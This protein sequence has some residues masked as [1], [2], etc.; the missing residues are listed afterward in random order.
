MMQDRYSSLPLITPQTV[1]DTILCDD[2][3]RLWFRALCYNPRVMQK[4]QQ[5]PTTATHYRMDRLFSLTAALLLSGSLTL[6]LI[7]LRLP[8]TQA[9]PWIAGGSVAA[10]GAWICFL[11]RRPHLA[12]LAARFTALEHPE[13]PK[14]MTLYQMG[15]LC[16]QK[17]NVPSLVGTMWLWDQGPKNTLLLVYFSAFGVYFLSL[18]KILLWTT[19][20]CLFT[21]G[22]IKVL[23][24]RLKP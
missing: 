1:H 15:E 22:C 20:A 16:S 18:G 21:A 10:L 9:L 17:Y 11:K 7:A 19:L 23:A 8:Q 14:G 13:M 12:C 24:S 3:T 2:Q 6:F 4:L 5:D